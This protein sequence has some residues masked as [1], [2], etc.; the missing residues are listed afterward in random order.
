MLGRVVRPATLRARWGEGLLDRADCTVL[1]QQCRW[2]ALRKKEDHSLQ[3]M[4]PWRSHRRKTTR[5]HAV[6][7]KL[8]NWLHALLQT[9]I[10]GQRSYD[11]NCRPQNTLRWLCKVQ[12]R[13]ISVSPQRRKRCVVVVGDPIL[14][15]NEAL[16]CEGNRT[17]AVF[18]VQ[19]F[20]IWL[21]HP[22]WMI[23]PEWEAW[24]RT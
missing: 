13:T 16:V 11:N 12:Y 9:L 10:M 1:E 21:R 19:W 3:E 4:I 15:G 2:G 24:T 20:T 8:Q 6:S 22:S 7:P 18:Q 17:C 14:R 5:S 23:F